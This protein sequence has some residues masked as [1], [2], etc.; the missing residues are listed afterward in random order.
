MDV[1]PSGLELQQSINVPCS[2]PTE[3]FLKGNIHD[4][5][6]QL[7]LVRGENVSAD[8]VLRSLVFGFRDWEY[9]R[10]SLEKLAPT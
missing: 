6:L 9:T 3:H 7:K 8:N 5:K 1:V 2:Y 4:H 10:N